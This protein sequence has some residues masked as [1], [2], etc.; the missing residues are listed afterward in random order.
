[1]HDNGVL[2]D[3]GVV[4]CVKGVTVAQHTG[5]KFE[6]HGGQSRGAALGKR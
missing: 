2:Q 1:L 4:T 6:T 5:E 3:I